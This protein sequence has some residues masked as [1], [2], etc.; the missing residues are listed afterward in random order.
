MADWVHL[1]NNGGTLTCGAAATVSVVLIRRPCYL[2]VVLFDEKSGRKPAMVWR[3]VAGV[4]CC[5]LVVG[6]TL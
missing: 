4:D 6:V 3:V 1:P 2:I 5:F